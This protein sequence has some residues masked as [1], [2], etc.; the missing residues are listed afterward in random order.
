M[1][2]AAQHVVSDSGE[3]QR[4]LPVLRDQEARVDSAM[5]AL[6]PHLVKKETSATNGLGWAAGHAAA[7]LAL[8][9]IH[10]Q[11]TETAGSA[12]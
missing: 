9:D 4:L 11:V 12:S 6:F 5:D 7:D 2:E 1:R 3:A 10:E 8:L